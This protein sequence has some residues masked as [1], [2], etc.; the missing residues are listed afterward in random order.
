MPPPEVQQHVYENPLVIYLFIALAVLS[1]AVLMSKKLQELLG[2]VGRYIGERQLRQLERRRKSL[3]AQGHLDDLRFQQQ[4]VRI[5]FLE[6]ELKEE[7]AEKAQYADQ[8]RELS[9]QLADVQ[10]QLDA[11]KD[12][13][14]ATRR[15]VEG[16]SGLSDPT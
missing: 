13:V 6:N 1:V 15:A 2:P 10:R 4:E 3:E 9:R 11:L 14:A 7:R 5:A 16:R 12:E 8:A